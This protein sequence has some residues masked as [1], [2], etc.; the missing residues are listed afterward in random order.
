MAQQTLIL[1]NC[2][3]ESIKRKLEDPSGR[4]GYAFKPNG[5][6][7]FYYDLEGKRYRFARKIRRYSNKNRVL[8]I[9]YVYVE[10]APPIQL[11]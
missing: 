2:L 6:I 10:D 11:K 9:G 1:S 5:R 8:F 3:L 7:Y 4:I